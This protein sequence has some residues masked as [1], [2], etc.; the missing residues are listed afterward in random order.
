MKQRD[1][2]IGIGLILLGA[3]FL[4]GPALDLAQ[5]GWPF[6][7]IVPG[8][9]LLFVAFTSSVSNGALAIPGA[10]LTAIGI[11]LLVF[12]LSG[13]WQ[14]WAYA[15][16]LILAAS[17]VGTY[18]QGMI[19]DNPKLRKAGVRTAT[20]GVLVAIGLGLFFE[21]L[22]FGSRSA[23]IRWYLPIALIVVGAV[24]LYLNSRR[25]PAPER[26]AQ[27][28][29]SVAPTPPTPTTPAPTKADPQEHG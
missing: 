7:V 13:H 23:F 8:V 9:A 10:V 27:V 26:A 25:R 20:Y 4:V 17:G 29:P 14:G 21:L 1:L 11:I 28:P 15:W 3:L 24:M 6:F 16:A 18:L 22:I 2:L 5:V 12:S 19:T